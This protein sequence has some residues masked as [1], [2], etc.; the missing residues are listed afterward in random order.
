VTFPLF[1]KIDVNG[2]HAHPLYKFLKAEQ[3]GMFATES[4]K[5]ELHQVPGRFATGT[6]SAVTARATRRRRLRSRW[7]GGYTNYF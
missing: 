5:W 1:Q 4:I 7:G 2:E 6:S 3:K